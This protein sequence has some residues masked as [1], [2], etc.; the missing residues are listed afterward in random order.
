[1]P[2]RAAWNLTLTTA[3]RTRVCADA[4]RKR[5]HSP[6]MQGQGGTA[7]ALKL[8]MRKEGNKLVSNAV[9][10]VCTYCARSWI[11]DAALVLHPAIVWTFFV[12]KRPI[13]SCSNGRHGKHTHR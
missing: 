2:Q 9:I 7:D 6:E 12:S 8:R 1:M 11:R 13:E 5:V 10:F 3:L 4:K